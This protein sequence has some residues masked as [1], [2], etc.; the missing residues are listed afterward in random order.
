MKKLLTFSAFLI[1]SFFCGLYI[2]HSV[3]ADVGEAPMP[4]GTITAGEKTDKIAMTSEDVLFDLKN[5]DLSECPFTAYDDCWYAH[6]TA[7]F[8]MTNTTNADETMSLIYPVP[9]I[10]QALDEY[11][12]ETIDQSQNFEVF[13]NDVSVPFEKQTY[14][15]EYKNEELIIT[16]EMLSL[17]FDVRFPADEDTNIRVEYDN[18]IVN[19]PKST[20][21]S[22]IYIM[23][24]GSNWKGTIGSGTI[25][26]QF[27]NEIS[28]QSFSEY[29]DFFKMQD[30]QLV[31]EFLNLE[32][33]ADQNIWISFSPDI[34]NIWDEKPTYL[35]DLTSSGSA[36]RMDL[37]QA[38]TTE[39]LPPGYE[40]FPGAILI[41]SDEVLL[42]DPLMPNEEELNAK[43]GIIFDT[44]KE[45]NP[46]IEYSFDGA[47]K[48]NSLS[49]FSGIPFSLARAETAEYSPETLY[50]LFTR[51]KSIKLTF[52]DGKS[53]TIDLP[54]SPDQLTT[55]FFDEVTTSSI[56]VEFPTVYP[57]EV[58]SDMFLGVARLNFGVGAKIADIEEEVEPEETSDKTTDTEKKEKTSSISGIIENVAETLGVSKLVLFIGIGGIFVLAVVIVVVIILIVKKKKKPTVNPVVVAKTEE[59]QETPK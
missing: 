46:W 21:R 22:M 41:E 19:N 30:N 5:Y 6:I 57:N 27:P 1:L 10:F 17:Q 3:R 37:N 4:G 29:N 35:R 18:R 55:V 52:S 50:T 38:W 31:W 25:R 56:T 49:I 12:D 54:D 32:P 39:I 8:Q 14:N 40:A 36:D 2:S 53:S 44:S 23:E 58:G 9:S 51:P 15:Y 13:I 28:E 11:Y 47:Y 43:P 59:K 16:P 7:Q 26:F 24:T 48:V 33:T 42:L 45:A 34:M 20:Y